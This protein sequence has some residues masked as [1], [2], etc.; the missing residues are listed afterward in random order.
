MQFAK[1]DVVSQKAKIPN[2][3]NQFHE[4]VGLCRPYLVC[5]ARLETGL[6]GRRSEIRTSDTGLEEDI[7][8]REDDGQTTA[9]VK[10][11]RIHDKKARGSWSVKLSTPDARPKH[12]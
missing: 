6:G 3:I 10:H 12:T 2:A 9:D 5:N 7:D 4:G 8:P 1:R 11:P